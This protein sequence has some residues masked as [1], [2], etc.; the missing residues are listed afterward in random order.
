MQ[1]IGTLAIQAGF[2]VI[3][4]AI[5]GPLGVGVALM[6]QGA[7][8]SVGAWINKRWPATPPAPAEAPQAVDPNVVG[9]LALAAMLRGVHLPT[10]RATP[11]P[12]ASKGPGH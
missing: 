8:W 7:A 4:G 12:P 1:L 5:F 11:P 6:L 2:T 3:A 10:P 9:L